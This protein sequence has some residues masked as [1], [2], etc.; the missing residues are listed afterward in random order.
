MHSST[1]FIPFKKPQPQK[2][3][4]KLQNKQTHASYKMNHFITTYQF[5]WHNPLFLSVLSNLLH[6]RHLPISRKTHVLYLF[7]RSLLGWVLFPVSN[8]ITMNSTQNS[9]RAPY[10]QL[11]FSIT[12]FIAD[13]EH[14]QDKWI[15]KRKGTKE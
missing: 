11:T 12:V 10:Q 9:F 7:V 2:K 6:H 1:C 5:S 15:M 4:Y 8:Q 13:W 3:I 14:M